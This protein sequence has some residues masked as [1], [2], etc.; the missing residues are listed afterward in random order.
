MLTNAELMKICSEEYW[1]QLSRDT[2]SL[3][4]VTVGTTAEFMA[5]I[6]F[7]YIARGDY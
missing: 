4:W 7:D 5:T 3:P 1:Y 2:Y 6:A